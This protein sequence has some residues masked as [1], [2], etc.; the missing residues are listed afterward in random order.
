MLIGF[1]WGD[2]STE[3]TQKQL[4]TP[5]WS[6]HEGNDDNDNEDDD[7]DNENED[8]VDDNR[9]FLLRIKVIKIEIGQTVWNS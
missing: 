3:T 9:G 8:D 7:N 4:H 6:I 2:Q 5:R 1:R